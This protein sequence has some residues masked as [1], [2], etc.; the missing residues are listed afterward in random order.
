MRAWLSQEGVNLE[1]RD[2]FKN[3]LT[4]KQL[5]DLIGDTHISDIFSWNSPSFKKLGIDK[6]SLDDDQLISMII[7]EPRLIRRPLILV[8]G[9][10]IP[11]SN[12]TELSRALN[13]S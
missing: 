3:R 13:L 4:E 8:N 2:L 7:K 10:L 5:R 6:E 11:G 12:K 9:R 1:E